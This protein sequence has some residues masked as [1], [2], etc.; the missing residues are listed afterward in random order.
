MSVALNVLAGVD[1]TKM[2]V[3]PALSPREREVV[4]QVML[5]R[6]NKQGAVELGIAEQTFKNHLR[7]VYGKRGINSRTQLFSVPPDIE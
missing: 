2:K 4:T 1:P 5:G 6:T 7:S 3:S